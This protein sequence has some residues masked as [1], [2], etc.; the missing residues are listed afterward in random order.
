[1]VCM[2]TGIVPAAAVPAP[3]A[4]LKGSPVK[5][6]VS[7]L[8]LLGLMA[9]TPRPPIFVLTKATSVEAV[10]TAR[11][12][13][14]KV[15]KVDLHDFKRAFVKKYGDESAFLKTFHADLATQLATGSAADGPRYTLELPSLDVDSFV[16]SSTMMVGGGPN[17]PAR[18][19]TTS[20]EYCVIKLDYRVR[21][22]NGAV[23]LEGK[24]Q[25]RTAKGEFFHPNQSKLANAVAGVQQHLADYL[26][27]RMPAE[28]IQ[29]PVPPAPAK[30]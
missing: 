20:T 27:G 25:E 11:F 5:A 24:V 21:A 15:Q 30:P 3:D 6:L 12:S 16:V 19:Q 14:E 10:K 2:L 17:M 29:N 13:L 28:N 9:C 8:L 1:M 18:M 7:L 4:P 26:R 23:M 22:T